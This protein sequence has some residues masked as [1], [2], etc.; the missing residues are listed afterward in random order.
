MQPNAFDPETK[1]ISLLWAFSSNLGG[2]TRNVNRKLWTVNL[3]V[4]SLWEGI[5]VFKKGNKNLYSWASSATQI[6]LM[7]KTFKNF[8][9]N[10]PK[11]WSI[12]ISEKGALFRLQ[13]PLSLLLPLSHQLASP[14]SHQHLLNSHHEL[15]IIDIYVMSKDSLHKVILIKRLKNNWITPDRKS[16]V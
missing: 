8:L 4:A 1:F 15:T 9:L 11:N 10:Q 16:V 14:T 2:K 7:A 3:Y 6:W 12:T 13:Q 5:K